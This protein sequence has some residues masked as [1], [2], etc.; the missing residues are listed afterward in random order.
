[1]IN[2]QQQGVMDITSWRKIFTSRLIATIVLIWYGDFLDRDTFVKV[3]KIFIFD[4]S[5][6]LFVQSYIGFSITDMYSNVFTNTVIRYNKF[7]CW[8][9]NTCNVTLFL[10]VIIT[11][12]KGI[13]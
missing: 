7:N 8:L 12:N 1:M 9:N 4:H 3:F 11:L 6:W 5:T 2:G 10:S 13:R